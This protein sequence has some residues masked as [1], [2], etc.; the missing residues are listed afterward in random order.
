LQY[1]QQLS[2]HGVIL[3]MET[4]LARA[5]PHIH[6]RI[7]ETALEHEH[8]RLLYEVEYLNSAGVVHVVYVDARR[9]T[10]ITYA[11]I[12]KLKEADEHD[13]HIVEECDHAPTGG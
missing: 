3:P 8:G 4:L 12:A 5:A 1:V 2:D 10:L 13:N 6:G 7:L 11:T 9:G